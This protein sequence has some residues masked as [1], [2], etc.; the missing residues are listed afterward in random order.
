MAG[1]TRGCALVLALWLG[2][3]LH[4]EWVD[5]ASGFARRQVKAE[6][7]ARAAVTRQVSDIHDARTAATLTVYRTIYREI[8]SRVS[9]SSDRRCT[10]P[11][12]LERLLDTAAAGTP[13]VSDPSGGADD[14]ASDLELSQVARSVVGN[15]AVC[16]QIRDQL[17]GLQTWIR[18]QGEG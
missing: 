3:R 6:E 13:E 7:T 15:Y 5:A 17:I 14:A 10:V 12:G 18:L 8:P 2:W 1:L 9:E 4:A 16:Q 11:V